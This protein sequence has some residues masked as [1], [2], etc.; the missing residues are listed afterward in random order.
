M[1]T[2]TPEYLQ[3]YRNALT[4]ATATVQPAQIVFYNRV[5]SAAFN[6]PD[7]LTF[8]FT[9]AAATFSAG[10]QA[11]ADAIA[12]SFAEQMAVHHA[13]CLSS[14]PNTASVGVPY[15]AVIVASGNF[16]AV[17]PDAD[18]WQ[19]VNGMLPPGLLLANGRF[20]GG[21]ALIVGGQ[22]PVSGTPVLVG[23]YM[24]TLK[25]TDP[26]GDFMQK[27]FTITVS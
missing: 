13:V 3:A 14:I 12:L 5:V 18:T 9:V 4:C 10:S 6:C 15:S 2:I 7:G 16:L 22:C 11:E 19:L 20:I 23:T 17:A 27:T 21:K 1:T 25:V 8:Y 24:F 26:A